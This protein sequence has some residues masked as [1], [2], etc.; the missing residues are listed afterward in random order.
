MVLVG[1]ENELGSLKNLFA[2]FSGG[3]VVVISGGIATGKTALLRTA[4]E[5]AAESGGLTLGAVASRSE[6]DLPL[7]V[8]EQLFRSPGLPRESAER[9]MRWLDAHGLS[10]G[11]PEPVA[12]P[13]GEAVVQVP[14]RVLRGMLGILRDLLEDRPVVLSVDDAHHAD[15]PS[16]QCLLYL[17]RRLRGA[18]LHVLF[19]E[20][21]HSNGASA[22][23]RSEFLREPLFRRIRLEPLSRTCLAE[24]AAAHLHERPPYDLV[25]ELYEASAGYPMLAQAF[26][27][28]HRDGSFRWPGATGGE[29]FGRAV[30]DFLYRH[31]S[32]VVELARAIAVLNKP[33]SPLLLAGVLDI[34]VDA[35]RQV[36]HLLTTA[37][38]LAD[39]RFRHEAF[40]AAV[41]EGTPSSTRRAAH[42]RI[43]DLLHNEGFPAVEVA[44]HI[45]A[46]GR[47]EAP[48][49][50]PIL[51]EAAE[52]A[53]AGDDVT[54]CIHYLRAA[55]QVCDERQ[56][57]VVV[58]ML[59]DAEWR[60]DPAAVL[61]RLHEFCTVGEGGPDEGSDHFIPAGYLLWHGRVREAL[62]ILEL[63]ASGHGVAPE[64]EKAT[65]VDLDGPGLWGA[66]LYP[67]LFKR[68]RPVTSRRH[69][70]MPVLL[71]P[72][73]QGADVI[74]AELVHGNQPA[75][76]A[77][78]EGL[79]QRSR[80][81]ERML[82]PLTAALAAF[83]YNDRLAEAAGWCDVLL[84]EAAGRRSPTWHALFAAER[85]M[86]HARQGELQ[87]AEEQAKAALSLISP[88]SWGVV[89]GLPLAAAVL[90]LTGKGE[91]DE[92]AAYL[93]VPVPEALFQT[94]M[95]LHYLCARGRYHLSTNHPHAALSD[96]LACG[97]LMGDWGIDLPG[98]EA[99]R[100][101]A[102]E[103]Y[104][105]IGD[106]SEAR[107]LG[108]EQLALI[109]PRHLRTQGM[110]LRAQAATRDLTARIAVLEEAV[111][112]LQGCGD[113]LELAHALADLG[114]ACL[115]LGEAK[116]ARKHAR[117][118][119]ALTRQC[120]AKA[121]DQGSGFD[122]ASAGPEGAAAYADTAPGLSDAERRV[123]TLAAAG[124]TNRE[125]S[126]K[127]FVTISTVEQHLTR[128]YRK[129]NVTRFDLQD[130]LQDNGAEL[131]DPDWLKIL[132]KCS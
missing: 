79:L 34:G 82:A 126:E 87:A 96:F 90:A 25:T 32:P 85:A 47:L 55:H 71:N 86:I 10:A 120:G 84:A 110:A 119:L 99:W 64:G 22:L 74:A 91:L 125:I 112:L 78:A 118:A 113:K 76:L 63:L 56:R 12:G 75:V 101:G 66:Y 49:V 121:L 54:T 44:A 127:L 15:V 4:G 83:T 93:D 69:D 98:V 108:D 9:A 117:K 67:A 38:V 18:R 17:V 39:G 30:L 45:V 89:V 16:L 129:L 105:Q 36:V 72:E 28:D 73:L 33:V 3:S 130:A 70:S 48:W 5:W 60:L 50:V 106:L 62:A 81:S 24:M 61:R 13:D 46:A 80:L 43:A 31:E 8:L 6:R 57:A 35:C 53:L 11:A 52:H 131:T 23:M 40:R 41:L 92:A 116:R 124:H 102:V 128:I 68:P 77:A 27:D 26:L 59:V 111:V 114:R 103:A 21:S 58:S 20:C 2:N 104:L 51:Q 37:K 97:R 1:R 7:G 109:D 123:A 107:A 94:R 19:G 115:L 14:A 42:A 65:T 122:A 88:P 29:A 95:G 100:S 132:V